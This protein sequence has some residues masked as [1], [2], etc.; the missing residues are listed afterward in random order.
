MGFFLVC[1][2]MLEFGSLISFSKSNRDGSL[3]AIL[4]WPAFLLSLWKGPA[5][6]SGMAFAGVAKAEVKLP[7]RSCYPIWLVGASAL[8]GLI[9]YCSD[10]FISSLVSIVSWPP[11]FFE[12][13]LTLRY[14]IDF[15]LSTMSVAVISLSGAVSRMLSLRP[16][17][18][19]ICSII[20]IR[21]LLLEWFYVANE[22][23]P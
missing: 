11:T 14:S 20:S 12:A 6:L 2:P 23:I 21:I 16:A 5:M 13:R 17:F 19:C 4:L 18:S 1:L 15:D 9:T 8:F 7:F 10:I 3:C 22:S